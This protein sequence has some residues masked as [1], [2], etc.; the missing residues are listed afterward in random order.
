METIKTDKAINSLK[1]MQT[2][3]VQEMN[4]IDRNDEKERELMDQL[5]SVWWN[6][7]QTII[8]IREI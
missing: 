4:S 8:N 7:D 6:I 1:N 3:L 5:D 2:I